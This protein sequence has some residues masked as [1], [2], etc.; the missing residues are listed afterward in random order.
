MQTI[1]FA[2]KMFSSVNSIKWFWFLIL[3]FCLHFS[4]DLINF[5]F[6][7]SI[8]TCYLFL[9]YS[10]I[11]AWL[12]IFKYSH[13]LFKLTFI[14][15]NFGSWHFSKISLLNFELTTGN[16]NPWT[17]VSYLGTLDYGDKDD[18]RPISESSSW[19]NWYW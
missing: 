7:V 12:L 8:F 16:N 5:R 17:H 2:K 15:N 1:R 10:P 6:F 9:W 19:S 3:I 4:N 14:F 11:L 13:F 18:D